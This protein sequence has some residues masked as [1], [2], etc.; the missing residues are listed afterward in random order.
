MA[1][2]GSSA[3]GWGIALLVA[4]EVPNLFSGLLPSL[5][6]ISTFT[7]ASAEKAEHAKKWIRKGEIQAAVVS[8]GL[9][10]GGTVVTKSPWPLLLTILMIMWLGWQY[11]SALRGAADGL[12]MDMASQ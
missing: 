10:V 9:G 3:E 11:E 7:N 8:L 12:R 1:A 6:T 2:P 5:F 4:F